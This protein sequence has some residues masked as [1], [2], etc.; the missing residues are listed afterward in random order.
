MDK[1]TLRVLEFDKIL[2]MVAE[3]VITVPGRNIVGEIKPL[4]N[5][6]EIKRNILLISETRRLL[7]GDRQS[8]IE[9]C[10][11]LSL[12]FRKIRPVDAVLDPFEIRS[13]LPLFSSAINLKTLEN[14]PDCEGLGE[15]VSRLTTHDAILKAISVSIDGEGMILDQASPELAFIRK[16]LKSCVRK[17]KDV[18]EGLLKRK[19]L[20]KHLQDYYLAER[21]NRWVIPVKSDSKGSVPGIIHDISNTGETV[22]IEPYAIQQIGNELES[23]KAEEKLEEYRILQRITSFLREHLH[24]IENDYSLVARTDALA[25]LARFADKLKMTPPEIN[26]RGYIRI[27]KG[28]HPVLWKTLERGGREGEI[29]PLDIELGKEN[30]CMVVTG[31]NAGGKTVALKTTGVLTLMALSG[32]HTPSA[33]GSTYPFIENVL[34]DIGDEQSI[35]ENLSTFSAHMTRISDIVRRSSPYMLVIIDELGTGTDPEQGGALSCAILRRLKERGSLSIVSTHLGMLKAFAHSEPGIINSAM[36][37]NETAPAG[38]STFRPTYKLVIGEPGTSHAFEIAE[39][40]GLPD[41]LIR[42]AREIME[43][44]GIDVDSLIRELKTKHNKLDRKIQAAEELRNEVRELR[45]NLREEAEKQEGD[46]KN[47]L[48]KALTDA[49]DLMRRTKAEAWKM[50]ES[51]KKSSASQGR[52]IIKSIDSRIADLAKERK[53]HAPETMKPL[54]DLKAGDAVLVGTLGKNGTLKSLNEKTGKCRV[55]VDDKEIMISLH[56][57]YSPAND[58]CEPVADSHR[59]KTK[60]TS[61]PDRGE[62]TGVSPELKVIGRR[63]DPALSLIERYLNDASLAGLNQVRI[64]HG[65]GTGILAS[66]IRDYL[67]EHPLV[68]K[69][70]KGNEDEGGEAVT[71]VFL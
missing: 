51:L 57:L 19:D 27:V 5:I 37:M 10:E 13:F 62:Y 1:H 64:I 71:I 43:G 21:N 11:D 26:D 14:D 23:L 58:K 67:N 22:Y 53:M 49:E 60:I 34:A 25:A 2:R 33:S 47:I 70:R 4:G 18:L 12:L 20:E 15:I 9:H 45:S 63:V 65:I 38:V 52:K 61:V 41:D 56:D 24:E 31:S 29:V 59:K 48:S 30:T 42:E 50:M 68:E 16:R 3:F 17:I 66:A 44:D 39:S 54:R 36:E 55:M 28:R 69:S 6:E 40:L 32:M 8:G 7:S 35:E 46:R